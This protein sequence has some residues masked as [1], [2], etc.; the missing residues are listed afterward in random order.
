MFVGGFPVDRTLFKVVTSEPSYRNTTQSIFKAPVLYS[1]WTKETNTGGA[2]PLSIT[3]RPK[4]RFA[5]SSPRQA[6]D[7]A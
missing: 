5:N 7:L 3:T 4:K 2:K 1:R 6:A